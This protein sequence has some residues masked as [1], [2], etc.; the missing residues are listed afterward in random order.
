MLAGTPLQYCRMIIANER[1]I[2]SAIYALVKLRELR[3]DV[4]AFVTSATA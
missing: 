1:R 3:R 2:Y 4:V